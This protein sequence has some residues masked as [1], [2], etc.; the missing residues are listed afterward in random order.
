MYTYMCIGY[1]P[2]PTLLHLFI[3]ICGISPNNSCLWKQDLFR[4]LFFFYFFC[5][6]NLDSIFIWLVVRN[7][8]IIFP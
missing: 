8:W 1:P 6:K 7:I 2:R 3:V 4:A 5:L